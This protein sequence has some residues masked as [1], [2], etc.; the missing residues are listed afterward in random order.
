MSKLEY[1]K[2]EIACI[3]S[4]LQSSRIFIT[5]LTDLTEGSTA[6]LFQ[7]RFVE[8]LLKNNFDDLFRGRLKTNFND[9]TNLIE[10]LMETCLNF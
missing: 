1:V 5:D 9:S 4:Q 7:V 2:G 10:F 3:A 8:F 6:E